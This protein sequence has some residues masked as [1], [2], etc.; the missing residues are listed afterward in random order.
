MTDNEKLIEKAKYLIEQA[1]SFRQQC[2][3]AASPTSMVGLW[4]RTADALSAALALFEKEHTPTG[5]AKESDTSTERVNNGA[6][7]SHVTPTVDEREALARV[8]RNADRDAPNP[9][10]RGLASAI[11]A[12]GFRHS[13]APE[14]SAEEP[15]CFA[16]KPDWP[17]HWTTNDKLRDLHAR[18]HEQKG[19]LLGREEC[20]YER[21]EFWDAAEF[22][23]R[24]A[25]VPIA[26]RESQGEPSD[27]QALETFLGKLAGDGAY[28]L[29]FTS[30][31]A[32][33]G[34]IVSLLK[35][36]VAAL[37]AAGAGGV[38]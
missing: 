22:T 37:R 35:R 34:H 11:L 12:A 36:D 13:E 18:W 17:E 31:S 15:E 19:N 23:L 16:E 25:D 24:L 30:A 27:A 1:G 3:D 2:G 7:S 14:P 6:D 20:G 10:S 21:C 33:H 28:T 26:G 32:L 38:R 5:H 8:I 4:F 9:W 29:D